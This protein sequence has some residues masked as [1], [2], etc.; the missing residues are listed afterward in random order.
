MAPG[1]PP[2]PSVTDARRA[3]LGQPVAKQFGRHGVFS[4]KI[5]AVVGQ[6]LIGDQ[7]KKELHFHVQV[8]IRS[9]LKRLTVRPS[10][11][12]GPAE[13]QTGHGMKINCITHANVRGLQQRRL[14]FKQTSHIATGLSMHAVRRRRPGGPQLADVMRPQ[15]GLGSNAV[16][17][18]RPPDQTPS[19]IRQCR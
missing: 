16:F 14:L 3:F 12:C 9:M 2:P 17:A 18:D 5:D 4:G 19:K 15:K 10:A 7:L 8:G 11:C 13:H 1:A 6:L